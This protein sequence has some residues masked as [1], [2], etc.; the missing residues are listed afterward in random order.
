MWGLGRPGRVQGALEPHLPGVAT[1]SLWSLVPA[2]GLHDSAVTMPGAGEGATWCHACQ[3]LKPVCPRAVCM[4]HSS[5]QTPARCTVGWRVGTVPLGRTQEDKELLWA[6][7]AGGQ[8]PIWPGPQV[9]GKAPGVHRALSGATYLLRALSAAGQLPFQ[10]RPHTD[11]TAARLSCRAVTEEF[12]G[13]V[14]SWPQCTARTMPPWR[15]GQAHG[16]VWPAVWHG[17]FGRGRREGC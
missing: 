13:S 15:Q 10:R 7:R 12:P 4:P 6:A 17:C 1:C 3:T 8:G 2:G 14:N 9:S 16:T 11:S 5:A